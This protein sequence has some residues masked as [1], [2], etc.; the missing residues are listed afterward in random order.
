M[1]KYYACQV[2]YKASII[3][4]DSAQYTRKL[5][6]ERAPAGTYDALKK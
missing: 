4:S 5:P 1:L 2:L 6:G 3:R